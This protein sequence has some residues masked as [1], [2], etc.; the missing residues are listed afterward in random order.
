MEFWIIFTHSVGPEKFITPPIP[1][2][3]QRILHTEGKA[4]RER[5]WWSPGTDKLASNGLDT[6]VWISKDS[7]ISNTTILALEELFQTKFEKDFPEMRSNGVESIFWAGKESGLMDI[8]NFPGII[9]TTEGRK[10]N[11]GMGAGFY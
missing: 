1:A 6:E 7:T 3:A 8:Y 4:S 9:Y 2:D 10:G 5:G 11:T